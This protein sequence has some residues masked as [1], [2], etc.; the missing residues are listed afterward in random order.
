MFPFFCS[1]ITPDFDNRQRAPS[2]EDRDLLVTVGCSWMLPAPDAVSDD[3]ACAAAAVIPVSAVSSCL[4]VF[5]SS[6]K[7]ETKSED[8]RPRR[9]VLWFLSR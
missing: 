4:A 5:T 6:S 7:S 3:C 9:S 1:S 2:P 8:S